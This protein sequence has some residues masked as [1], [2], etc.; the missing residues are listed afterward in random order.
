[1]IETNPE[2]IQENVRIVFGSW[3]CFTRRLGG[4]PYSYFMK[5]RIV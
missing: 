1:M 2:E 5:V 3:R 4:L